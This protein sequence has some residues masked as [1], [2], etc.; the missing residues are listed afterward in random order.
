ME[1]DRSTG[2]QWCL[3]ADEQ[4]QECPTLKL[5]GEWHELFNTRMRLFNQVHRPDVLQ[6][7]PWNV[8]SK[9]YNSAVFRAVV[10]VKYPHSHTDLKAVRGG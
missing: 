6:G 4:L 7:D 9:H 2:T 8:Q 3:L 5:I 10:E 1:R